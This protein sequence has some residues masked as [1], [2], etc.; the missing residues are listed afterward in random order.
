MSGEN[1]RVKWVATR[2]AKLD[3]T[4]QSFYIND[5]WQIVEP[6]LREPGRPLR[7]RQERRPPAASTRSTPRR[8]CRAWRSPTTCSATRR[9]AW[10]PRT[11]ATPGSTTSRRS[12]TTPRSATRA[13]CTSTTPGR[14]ASAR[15]FA[16]AF[17]TAN[18]VTFGGAVPTVNVKFDTKP[19]LADDGRVHVRGVLHAAAERLPEGHL[20]EPQ[21]QQLHRELH[22]HDDGQ[23][24]GDPR[25]PRGRTVRQRRLQELRTCPPASTRGSPSS[26][27]ARPFSRWSV[28]AN[29]T[30][31]LK[32]DGDF[33]GEA[34]NQPGISSTLGRLPRDLRR[35]P[36]L[37]A[38]AALGLPAAQGARLDDLRPGPRPG[39]RLH[40][41]ADLSLRLGARPAA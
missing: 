40:A 5:Y 20:H 6:A 11:P 28:N 37:P 19:P 4:T 35:V 7:D 22:R 8:S 29:Y 36:E 15:D 9:S 31:Q 21:D 10:T 1:I 24:D 30:L 27:I 34:R 38:R 41:V 13:T 3:I 17:D 32:N 16:P 23:L 14:A 39:R 25:G 12:A 2:G 33:E 18:W 26:A